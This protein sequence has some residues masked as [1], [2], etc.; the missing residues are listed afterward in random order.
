ML[1]IVIVYTLTD[2]YTVTCHENA[3]YK[4]GNCE[5]KTNYAG[6]GIS[7]C[8]RVQGIYNNSEID[9]LIHTHANKGFST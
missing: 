3:E 5:C 7:S 9:I 4:A 8:N 2:T 1:Y 6:D